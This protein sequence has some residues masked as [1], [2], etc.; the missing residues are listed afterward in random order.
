[1][2]ELDSFIPEAVHDPAL[3]E[4]TMRQYVSFIKKCASATVKRYVTESDDEWAVALQAFNEAMDSYQN[5]K[6]HFLPFAE[7]VIKRRLTDYHHEQKRF[8]REIS[9]NPS[10][11]SGEEEEEDDPAM[12]NAIR[13]AI[14]YLPGRDLPEEIAA[15]SDVLRD[16]GFSFMDL[17]MCSPKSQKTKESCRK[18]IVFLLKNTDLIKDMQLH[19]QLPLKI[20]EK[21]VGVPRKILERHRKYIIAATEILSGEYPCLAEYLQPMRKE[22]FE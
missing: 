4:T 15:I 7:M 6:G 18:A 19:R 11:F 10:A 14:V 16:Y 9:V 20:L 21:N 13:Q 1:M 2:N 5:D 17:T 8:S 12:S 22:R 3:R